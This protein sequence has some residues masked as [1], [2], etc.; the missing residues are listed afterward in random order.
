MSD[1]E[2][3]FESTSSSEDLSFYDQFRD[4]VQPRTAGEISVDA[5]L[6]GECVLHFKHDLNDFGRVTK[7]NYDKS[8][9]VEMS[10]KDCYSEDNIMKLNERIHP[11]IGLY[12]HSYYS[13][14]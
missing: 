11:K 12:L 10:M 1:P 5:L 3:S 6:S 14:I 2:E 8:A 7:L 13:I 4:I 9:V